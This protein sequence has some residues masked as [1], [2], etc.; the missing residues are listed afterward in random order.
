MKIKLS[1]G[2]EGLDVD[3]S[4]TK[5]FLGVLRGKEPDVLSHP[6]EDLIQSLKN[7][8]QST[9]FA[10]ITK[11]KISEKENATATIVISDITRPVPNKLILPPVLKTLE[12]NGV[13]RENIIILIGTGIHRPNEGDELEALVGKEISEKYRIE[14]HKAKLIEEM[15]DCGKT[16]DGIPILINKFYVNAD[17]KILT[18]FIEPHMWAGYSGGRKSILP[19]VSSL[20]TMKYMHGF[21]M[22]AHPN[23][24]YGLLENNPFHNAGLEVLEKVGCDF[25]VNVTLNEKKEITGIFS[26]H[27]VEAHLEGCQFLDQFCKVTLDEPLDFIVTTNSGAP[28][29]CNLYQTVKGITGAVPIVK[30]GGTILSTSSCPEGK[31]EDDYTELV[32][33]IESAETF[34]NQIQKPEFFVTDQWGAQEL[35]QI[36]LKREIYIKCDGISGDWL[37]AR[38]ITP[39][40]DVESAVDNLLKKYG[41]DAKWAVVPDGPLT[42]L[43]LKV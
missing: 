13:K 43:S 34:I 14:N 15:I 31:G 36:L 25:I 7:P 35:W 16:K 33:G 10:E 39:V 17:L 40:E 11:K 18:G 37:Q 27:P 23:T 6:E 12:E 2:K 4:E 3:F 41:K 30:E 32:N 28:L 29:D 24:R 8:I 42:I 38:G 21:E 5:G 22:V 26:G 1:Y 9:S 20:E 19:G